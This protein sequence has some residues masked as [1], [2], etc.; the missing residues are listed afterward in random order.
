MQK[1]RQMWPRTWVLMPQD[2]PP[3][4][5]R[6]IGTMIIAQIIVY[7]PKLSVRGL[8]RVS[9][10]PEDWTRKL[11]LLLLVAAAVSSS[12]ADAGRQHGRDRR[13][14]GWGLSILSDF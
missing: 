5:M 8:A 2:L 10:P 7:T 6:K 3:G 12:S 14:D 9:P 4:C 11:L 13:D 1:L